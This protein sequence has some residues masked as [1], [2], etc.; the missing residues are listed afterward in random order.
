[1]LFLARHFYLLSQKITARCLSSESEVGECWI[2]FALLLIA[3]KFESYHV[4]EHNEFSNP[5][6][7]I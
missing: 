2:G 7:L 3:N 4:N 1:M 5:N 6:F